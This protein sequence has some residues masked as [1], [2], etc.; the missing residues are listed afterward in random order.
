MQARA[1]ERGE[2]DQSCQSDL[3]DS[4]AHPCT[5]HATR[6]C[7]CPDGECADADRDDDYG[8]K[9]IFHIRDKGGNESGSQ[10]GIIS[11]HF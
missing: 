6:T 9:D 1:N 7:N 8:D 2:C 3:S 10:G 5:C 11:Q 4:V